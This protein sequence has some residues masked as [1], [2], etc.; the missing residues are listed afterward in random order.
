[1]NAPVATKVSIEEIIARM[2][3]MQGMLET[4]SAKIST[5]EQASVKAKSDKEMTDDDARK[6]LIGE[7]KDLKH[8]EAAAK[9]GLSYGQVYSCRGEYTFRHIHKE[10]KA[11]PEGFKNQ[12]KK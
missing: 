9:T 6:I 10:L 5:F 1:M 12:W 11:R 8:N 2:D 7:F 3:H 4:L